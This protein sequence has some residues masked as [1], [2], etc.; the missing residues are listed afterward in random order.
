METR[1]GG[2]TEEMASNA[3]KLRNYGNDLV[4]LLNTMHRL[5]SEYTGDGDKDSASAGINGQSNVSLDDT[6]TQ[7]NKDL[8]D[9]ANNLIETADSIDAAK[10]DKEEMD[11]QYASLSWDSNPA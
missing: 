5:V 1:I 8:T 9:T 4:D 11:T 3:S 6:Y 2:I 7:A 10:N